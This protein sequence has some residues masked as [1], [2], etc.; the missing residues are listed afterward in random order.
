M[1]VRVSGKHMEIG[2]SFRTRIEDQIT[3]AVRKY[4]DGGFSSHVIVEKSGSRFTADCKIH[5]DTGVV[6]HATGDSQDPQPA[7]DA[8]AERVEK[9]LRR[10]KRR[11]KDHHANGQQTNAQL[12]YAV[13]DSANDDVEEV[14]VDYAPAIIAESTKQLVTMTVA[15]AVMALD[16]TD[17]RIL[18]FRN[19]GNDALN[20]V[21]RRDDGN[22]GW[23]DAGG[24]KT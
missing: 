17:E 9:R 24:A 11:L 4:Y 1:S 16:M 19:A 20:V 15:R 10:Y 8:A 18:M 23:I 2:E 12:A 14:P 7:F 3:G 5:L 22:I 21:Y 13:V 6:L